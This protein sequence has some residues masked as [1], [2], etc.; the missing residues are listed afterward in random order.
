VWAVDFQFDEI[1]DRRRLKLCNI[2]DEFTREALAIRVA[3]NCT[4]ENVIT[5]IEQLVA[6]RGALKY[7]HADNGPEMIAWTL[8]S[9]LGDASGEHH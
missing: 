1:A 5:T 8:Q 4:A 6:E 3:R 9:A 2:V 7:L